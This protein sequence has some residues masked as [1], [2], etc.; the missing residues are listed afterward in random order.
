MTTDRV[1]QLRAP[2]HLIWFSQ[3][4]CWHLPKVSVSPS[5]IATQYVPH[6][7]WSISR[8]SA[9]RYSHRNM[10]LTS[11]CK[12]SAVKF[13]QSNKHG[14]T[15]TETERAAEV[16]VCSD[17]RNLK[18]TIGAETAL[19]LRPAALPQPMTQWFWGKLHAAKL[20]SLC[21]DS[22]RIMFAEV[23]S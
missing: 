14:F 4:T 11:L 8:S 21:P 12:A 10:L 9:V 16:S 7:C 17:W 20:S 19:S 3:L 15:Q 18:N 13:S 6:V 22:K 1:Y 5:T 23:F 2:S